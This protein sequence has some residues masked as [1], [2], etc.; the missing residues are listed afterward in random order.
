M[1]PAMRG[2]KSVM[3]LLKVPDFIVLVFF[4]VFVRSRG[5]AFVEQLW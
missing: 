4:L 1:T 2:G 5:V 3:M